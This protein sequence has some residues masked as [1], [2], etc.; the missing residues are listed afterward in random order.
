[1]HLWRWGW[2]VE[3]GRKEF[4]ATHVMAGEVPLMT[5]G[6]LMMTGGILLMTG[7]VL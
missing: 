5:N 7:E 2:V 3:W 4:K 6:V 1:M